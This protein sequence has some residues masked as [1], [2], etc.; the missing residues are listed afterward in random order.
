M[1]E[2]ETLRLLLRPMSSEHL[3]DLA[4]MWSDPA[5]TR[6]LPT[7]KPRS[8]ADTRRELDFIEQ[9]WRTY[10]FGIWRMN[11]KG[12]AEFAGYCGLQHLHSRPGQML[13]PELENN[14][15]VEILFGVTRNLWSKGI[16]Y[17]AAKATVRYGFETLNLPRILAAT[18]AE[19]IAS[20]RIL[21]KLGMQEDAS[22]RFY[23]DFPHFVMYRQSFVP[24]N[25]IYILH[26]TG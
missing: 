26:S 5:V 10:G 24:D 1:H 3:E 16:A 17:E 19:N 4:R 8:L 11:I 23:G 15:D 18:A 21:E 22:L 14:R 9:H 25:A 13:T 12:R 6:Y 20:Q 7:G 2:I